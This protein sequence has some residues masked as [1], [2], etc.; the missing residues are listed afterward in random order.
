MHC[1]AVAGDVLDS[2]LCTTLGLGAAIASAGIAP[3]AAT[4]VSLTNV[5]LA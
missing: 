4:A 3:D 2:E 5:P 1:G